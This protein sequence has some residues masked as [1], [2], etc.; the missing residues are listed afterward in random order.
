MSTPR[1]TPTT[2]R[3]MLLAVPIL[4]LISVLALG[5]VPSGS[6]SAIIAVARLGT[7]V[8]LLPRG[9]AFSF[10]PLEQRMRVLRED[11]A[12]VVAVPATIHLRDGSAVGARVRLLLAG[13]G[14]LPV[15]AGSIREGGWENAW[16][17]WL[18]TKFAVSESEAAE[19]VRSSARWREVFPVTRPETALD[20]TARL[21]PSFPGARLESATLEAEPNPALV[22]TLAMA[23]LRSVA[24]ENGRL[25]VVGLDALDWGLVDE[26]TRRGVMPNLKR[27][28]EC[29]AQVVVR[30]R[31]PLL[32]PLIWTTLATGQPPEVHGVLDFVE[33]DPRGGPAQPVTSASRKVP[34]LWEMAAVAG[35]T[36]AVIGWW[37]TFPAVGIPGCTIYSDRLSEQLTDVEEERRGLAYPA[38]AIAVARRL[39]AH[40]SSASPDLLAPIL[41]VTSEELAAVPKGPAGWDDPIGGAARLMA[42]TVTV[43][44]LTDHELEKGTNVVLAYVEGTDTVGHLFARYRPPAMP[45]TDPNLARRLGPVVDRYHAFI[46]V[47]LGRV[48]ARLGPRDTIVI[49]SDHGFRWQDRPNVSSGAHT[50]T[51]VYWHRPDALLVAA[52][53]HI[54][55]DASRRRIDPLDV[56]PLLLALAGLP[57][58]A[59]VPGGVPAG[60][61]AGPESTR[62][63]PVRYAALVSGG[64]TT[65]EE[66]PPAGAEEALAKLRALGY[67]GGTTP[68]TAEV[69]SRGSE[70]A[71]PGPSAE[72]TANLPHLEA[73]RLHNLAV[74][75]A[76]RGELA[77]AATMFRQAIAAD[78][79]YSPPHYALARVLRLTGDLAEADRELWTAIDLGIADPPEALTQV[80]HE[81]V[82]MGHP[83]R[84]GAVLAEAGRRYPED[85]RI[86]LD[87]GTLAG[88]QGDLALARQCLE[89]AVS[90]APTNPLARRNLGMAYLGLG[91]QVAARRAFAEALR[92]DPNDAEVRKQLERLGG[93][94]H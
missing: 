38:E 6:D 77:A 93:P 82:L 45:G 71:T 43:Q 67:I 52:G 53:P 78:A 47:W 85:A 44:R 31:P 25:V 80:A 23:E 32:S 69:T 9:L 89:R 28:L 41:S 3:G 49:L 42:A 60:F 72:P 86:W 8:R 92:L 66:A 16:S 87:L 40:Y 4:A 36:S 65:T 21:S 33:P 20:V 64:A 83:D 7:G 90:L 51:A 39:T 24:P 73:R 27:L 79:S 91:D 94:P 61:V 29:G 26:L 34:A 35:R 17:K 62:A 50:P 84:A 12:A 30:M 54:R 10:L 19:A 37:A 75:L 88:Q 18:E 76:D 22:R 5:I 48:A 2:R 74:G 1:A 46:D 14:R 68:S 70:T 57:R 15:T 63:A 55:P 13:A 56:L 58:A 59:D 11:N 81:Y